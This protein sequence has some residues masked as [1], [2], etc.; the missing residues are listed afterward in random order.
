MSLKLQR[1]ILM[2]ISDLEKGCEVD[3]KAFNLSEDDAL[4]VLSLAYHHD[5]VSSKYTVK[6]PICGNH[7]KTEYNNIVEVEESVNK[8]IKCDNE[9]DLEVMPLMVTYYRS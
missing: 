9:I 5:L 8:C 3:L 4:S 7:D 2:Y 1:E 6:C